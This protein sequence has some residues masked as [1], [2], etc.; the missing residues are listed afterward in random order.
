MEGF[1]NRRDAGQRLAAELTRYKDAEGVIVLG[2]PRGGVPVAEV[3][4]EELAAPLSVFIVRKLGVPGHRELAMG[5]IGS[6]DVRFIN[7]SIVDSL[8]V[9][10]QEIEQVERAERQKL[11]E[12]ERAYRGELP[13]LDLAGKTVILVDDGIAT[14][15]TVRAAIKALRQHQVDKLILAVPVAAPDTCKELAAEVE[16]MICLLQ[17]DGFAAIGPYYEDFGQTSDDEVRE[18]LRRN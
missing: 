4:A 3:V 9:S 13:E 17:P 7:R 2:L 16:E 8:G 5:A 10:E 15:A 1:K 12:R 11:T 6:G 14:G 18:I